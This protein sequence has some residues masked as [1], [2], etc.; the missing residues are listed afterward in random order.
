MKSMKDMKKSKKQTFE[1]TW[2][3]SLAKAAT[4]LTQG[5][6]AANKR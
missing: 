2:K 3:E 6:M 1:N 4:T 5:A